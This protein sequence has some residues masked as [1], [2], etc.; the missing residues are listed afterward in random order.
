[1]SATEANMS[2]RVTRVRNMNERGFG[3]LTKCWGI[4]RHRLPTGLMASFSD[5]YRLLLSIDNAFCAPLWKDAVYDENDLRRIRDRCSMTS[6][7]ICEL[8]KS[9]A[10]SFS[11]CGL[12]LVLQWA[13]SDLNEENLRK[14][15]CGPYAL[16]LAPSY[17]ENISEAGLSFSCAVLGQQKFIKVTGFRS[18][19]SKTKSRT[20][21]ALLNS[22]LMATMVYCTCKC[23]TRT[24]G[25]CSHGIALLYYLYCE[26]TANRKSEENRPSRIML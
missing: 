25:S 6:N 11:K 26:R 19:F 13:P 14:W 17:I 2:R 22:C 24:V 4:L 23:G 3:R 21:W 5:I 10:R 1:M 7:P 15:N 9:K 16:H 20:V 12:G 18:R 8:L